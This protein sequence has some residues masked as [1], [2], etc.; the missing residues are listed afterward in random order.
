MVKEKID[1]INYLAAEK[2]VR[3]L[4]PEELEEQAALRQEYLAEIR[5]SLGATL[6]NTVI[7]RP[8]GTREQLKKKN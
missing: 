2:K 7:E 1:R 8:D 6:G 4:T 5:A 3:E